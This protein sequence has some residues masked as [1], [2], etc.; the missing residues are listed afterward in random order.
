MC[1]KI[2]MFKRRAHNVFSASSAKSQ[3]INHEKYQLLFA[4]I[5]TILE[6]VKRHYQVVKIRILYDTLPAASNSVQYLN[7]ALHNDLV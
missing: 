1:K 5:Q 2:G 7:E 3:Q 4:A 6:E